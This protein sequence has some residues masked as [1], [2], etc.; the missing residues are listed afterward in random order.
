MILRP[1]PPR[2]RRAGIP[3]VFAVMLAAAACTVPPPPAS[4]TAAAAPSD[5]TAAPAEQ[6]PAAA[7][8]ARPV[9]PE[10]APAPPATVAVAPEPPPPPPPAPSILNGLTGAEVTHLIGAPRFRR[11]EAPSALWQYAAAG[12]ILDLYLR[13]DGGAY[14]VVHYEFRRDPATA[15]AG[16][17]ADSIDA[18]ACFAA[19][20]RGNG[21]NR[22]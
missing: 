18:R 3:I 15:A 4:E 10:T 22:G 6:S 14:R 19:M 13:N 11:A 12:C 21:E 16:I 5:T 1:L 17:T 7:T 9:A 2:T 20:A 8:E